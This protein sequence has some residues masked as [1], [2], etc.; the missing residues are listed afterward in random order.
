MSWMSRLAAPLILVISWAQA[1]A[2]AIAQGYPTRAVTLVVAFTP[3][4]PSDVIARIYGRKMEELLGQSFIVLNRPGA[5]GNL[6]AEQVAHAPA[7]G[8]MLL[9][10][11]NGI[12]ATNAALYKRPGYDAQKDFAPIVLIGGQAN[13]LVVNPKVAAKTTMEVATLARSTNL[14]YASSGHG[15]A[16][17][18]SAELF[19]SRAGVDIRHVPYKGAAPALQDVIS[20]EVHMMFATAASVIGHIRTTMVRPIAVTTPTRT[21]LLPEVPTIHE[22]GLPDFDAS[23]W[24]GIVAPAATPKEIIARLH[25]ASVQ[26]LRD[27]AVA[28]SLTDL[29][30]DIVASGPDAFAAYIASEIPKWTAVV[31]ASGAK[32]E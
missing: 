18:L 6:A 20:G 28:K 4:G 11:N 10:G 26:A 7:D 21:A 1:L 24:H 25:A 9:M 2:P 19:K 30:V 12:L 3:G 13:I 27:P 17:H 14:T 31:K 32:M 29:G 16:A 22:Q 15:Q 23:S 5:G 8:Y